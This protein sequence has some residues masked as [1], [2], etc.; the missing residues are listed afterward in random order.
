LYGGS[1]GRFL[2]GHLPVLR[3]RAPLADLLERQLAV[4]PQVPQD[5]DEG[6]PGGGEPER[7][8]HIVAHEDFGELRE[9]VED[10]LPEPTLRERWTLSRL[11]DGLCLG[12]TGCCVWYRLF[13][14]VLGG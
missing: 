12:G 10:R 6:G 2:P 8:F 5:P 13:A 1:G 3:P 7:L 4:H 11:E 9:C 14:F